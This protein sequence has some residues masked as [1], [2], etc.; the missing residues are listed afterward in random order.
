MLFLLF[1]LVILFFVCDNHVIFIF[2]QVFIF[3]FL[4]LF[5]Q[6]LSPART[7]LH[8]FAPKLANSIWPRHEHCEAAAIPYDFMLITHMGRDE[9]G[10]EYGT[11]TLAKE[12][13]AFEKEAM[14][15]GT[16]C[17]VIDIE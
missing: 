8:G 6:L 15:N 13:K 16:N 7:L 2:I 11:G 17:P 10:T 5:F 9:L 1:S 12:W 14:K 4:F 3:L